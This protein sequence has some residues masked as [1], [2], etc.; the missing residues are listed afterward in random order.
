[1]KTKLRK[2]LKRIIKILSSKELRILPAYLAYSFV[3]AIIPLL[4]IIVVV[5]SSFSI[6]INTILNQISNIVPE[7]ISNT[8][9]GAISSKNF[10]LS[11]GFLSLITFALAS[12]GMYAIIDTS[13]SL[14]KVEKNSEIKNR[15]KSI[16]ILLIVIALL[17]F[18]FIFSMLGG[19]ILDLLK[20]YQI[21]INISDEINMVY[22]AL[23]W[24]LTFLIIFFNIKLIYM[25][26]PSIKVKSSETTIGAFVTTVGW[27]LFTAI[28]NYY[29]KY[30][31]KYDLIYGS[32]S[33]ITI[34]L[35]W[36]YALCFILVLG[37]VINTL[38]YNKR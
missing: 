19:G 34:L 28:F 3:L 33:G 35:I 5:A 9:I 14:Y 37:I 30:F 36:I 21:L 6:S 38:E 26:A 4:T 11:I 29:I 12:K 15:L 13:N 18:I 8:I 24:P 31:G 22:E 16:F 27:V 20:K 2:S 17:L 10:D 25:I 32:L 23:K 7:Y 1:M